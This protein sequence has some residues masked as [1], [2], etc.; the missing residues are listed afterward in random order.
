MIVGARPSQ[1]QEAAN[2]T[3]PFV[4]EPGE[5]PVIELVSPMPGFPDER[6]YALVQ[7]DDEGTLCALR[8]LER[9]GLEF[10]VVPPVTFF[11]SYAPEVDAQVVAELG[12]EQAADAL[13]LVVV[14]AGADLASTTVNLRAPLV[15]GLASR[16]AVQVVLDDPELSVAAPLLA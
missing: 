5:I 9:E 3:A 11:P 15:V 6:R 14:H 12:I 4:S 8:S 2:V 13:L 16:R 7:L 1:H 10:L